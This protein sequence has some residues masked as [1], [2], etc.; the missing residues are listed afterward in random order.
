[1]GEALKKLSEFISKDAVAYCS[2]CKVYFEDDIP[3]K[4]GI[5]CPECNSQLIRGLRIKD[6]KIVDNQERV[7]KP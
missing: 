1:M 6:N 5:V 3:I 4:G 2:T 7:F